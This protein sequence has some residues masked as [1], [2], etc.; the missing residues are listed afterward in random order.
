MPAI[1]SPHDEAEWLSR[2]KDKK[3]VTGLLRPFAA[4]EMRA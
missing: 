4:E 3:S 2:E 1:I